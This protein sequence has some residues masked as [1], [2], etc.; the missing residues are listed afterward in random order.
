MAS[1]KDAGHAGHAGER[2]K[3]RGQ[4]PA[5]QQPGFGNRKHNGAERSG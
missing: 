2:G 1:T 4:G 5:L 3:G